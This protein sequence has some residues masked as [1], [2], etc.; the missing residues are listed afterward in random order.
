MKALF[1]SKPPTPAHLVRQLRDLLVCLSSCGDGDAKRGVKVRR[2]LGWRLNWVVLDRVC[3][4][5]STFLCL[6]PLDSFAMRDEVRHG[7]D[8]DFQSS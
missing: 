6:S 7:S 4:F 5:F 1:K 8:D 2:Y 3:L